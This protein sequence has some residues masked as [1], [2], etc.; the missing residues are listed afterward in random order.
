MDAALK[1]LRDQGLLWSVFNRNALKE[2]GA[3]PEARLALEAPRGAMFGSEARGDLVS[4]AGI[5]VGSHG[6]FPNRAGLEA[7]FIAWGPGINGG[8]NLH[9]ISMTA[10]GPTL[11][12]ALGIDDPKFGSQPALNS[13]FK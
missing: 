5:K 9:R 3:D 13:I 11:L 2:L 10:V 4:D 12:K 6:Y 8:V 7:S 1:P